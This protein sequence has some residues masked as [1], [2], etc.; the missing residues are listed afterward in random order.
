MAK[1]SRIEK[2]KKLIYKQ[3][4]IRNICTSAHIH[5]GKT[6]MTAN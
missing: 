1:E 4:N 3:S 2:F 5:H 6:A